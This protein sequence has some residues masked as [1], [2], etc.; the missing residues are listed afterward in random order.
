MIFQDTDHI[1]SAAAP[2]KRAFGKKQSSADA[3]SRKKA[4]LT[5]AEVLELIRLLPETWANV[6]KACRVF[7]VPSWEVAFITRATN[8]EGEHQL[9]VTKGKIYKTRG[10]VKEET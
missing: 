1:A 3:K 4:V 2:I 6:I 8:D 10:G 9:R 7:G 5:D